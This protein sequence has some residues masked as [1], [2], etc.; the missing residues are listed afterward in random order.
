[1]V[2]FT[3]GAP[4]SPSPAG[5]GAARSMSH[6]S[7]NHPG[8]SVRR[9]MTADPASVDGGQQTE[10]GGLVRADDVPD[11][12]SWPLDRVAGGGNR[13]VA[14]ARR[15]RK[16]RVHR[17]SQ[18]PFT[19]LRTPRPAARSGSSSSACSRRPGPVGQPT[20][21][22]LKGAL[23]SERKAT[24]APRLVQAFIRQEIDPATEIGTAVTGFFFNELTKASSYREWRR[25]G[26]Q[27]QQPTLGRCSASHHCFRS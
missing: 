7:A 16:H 15:R 12:C 11:L 24:L 1:M 21:T 6:R 5:G 22:R 25:P 3:P 17:R 23:S 13:M 2:G 14:P 10:F 26:G 8:E 27:A 20:R 9:V 4:R 18:R 19:A